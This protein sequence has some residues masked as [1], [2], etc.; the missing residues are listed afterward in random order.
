MSKFFHGGYSLEN[1]VKVPE[2]RHSNDARMIVNDLI[3]GRF[4]RA[5][6]IRLMKIK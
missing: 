4:E 5:S 6:P 2:I 3:I 1:Q